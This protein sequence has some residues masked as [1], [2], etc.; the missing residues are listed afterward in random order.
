MTKSELRQNTADLY[1]SVIK[2]FDHESTVKLAILENTFSD[3]YMKT[4]I[5][6][7]SYFK[8]AK[9]PEQVLEI[10]LTAKDVPEKIY[11]AFYDYCQNEWLKKAYGEVKIAIKEIEEQE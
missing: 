11:N 2:I 8:L 6:L 7:M 1:K 4:I 3:D 10:C 5:L 9:V